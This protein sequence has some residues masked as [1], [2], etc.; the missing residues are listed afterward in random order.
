MASGRAAQVAASLR[1]CSG[2]LV[3][4]SAS[5]F[6]TS[7]MAGEPTVRIRQPSLCTS[8]SADSNPC[9]AAC[10]LADLLGV[11]AYNVASSLGSSSDGIDT[12]SRREKGDTKR[13][14]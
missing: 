4:G 3:L 8:L 10:I 2:G 7:G 13:Q 9:G 12:V 1:T 5:S 11:L 6:H 14:A